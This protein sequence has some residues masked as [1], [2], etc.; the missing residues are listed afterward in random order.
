MNSKAFNAN[1]AIPVEFEM[2]KSE[3]IEWKRILSLLLVLFLG[4]ILSACNF[5]GKTSEPS[6]TPEPSKTQISP[7]QDT[8]IGTIGGLVWGDLCINFEEDESI[9]PGCIPSSGD[10]KFVGN[11]I[12]DAGEMGVASATVSLGDGICPSQGNSII[13]TNE[14]GRYSFS[15][16]NPGVYCVTVLDTGT[17]SGVWTYPKGDNA[18]GVGHMTVTLTPG[19]IIDD[20][21]FAWDPIDVL[22]TPAPTA[23]PTSPPCKDRASYVRDVSVP[24][25]TRFDPEES[26]TKTWRFRNEG[27]C[28]WT[29]NYSVVFVSGYAMNASPVLSL[30]GE[31][32]PGDMVDITH[33]FQAPMQ[34]GEYAG[35]WK[36]RNDEGGLF[37]IGSTGRSPFWVQIKVGP[38]PEPEITDWRGAYYDNVKFEGDPVLI[39][40][41]EEIDFDWKSNSPNEEVPKDQ[42][43]VQW[44]R[45]LE[46]QEEIVRFH[47]VMDD[48][49]TLWVDEQLVIDEW[50]QGAS[51][52]V[53][54]D[55]ELKKGKHDLKVEY[56]EADGTAK[57]SLWWETIDEP[58]YD[59]WKGSYWFNKTLDSEWAL[60]RDDEMIDFEWK[61]ESPALGIPAD[62]FSISWERRVEFETGIYTFY[63]KADDGLRV[64]VDEALVIDEWHISNASELYES[65]LELSGVHEI[66]ILYYEQKQHATV[67]FW[68][69]RN[70]EAP[71]AVDDAYEVNDSTLLQVVAPGVLENDTDANGDLLLALLEVD[72][73]NGTLTLNDDGSFEYLPDPG[74]F[75]KDHFQY[76]ASDGQKNSEVAMVTIDVILVNQPPE[77]TADNFN[78]PEDDILNVPDIGVLVN[79]ND[80][81]G[82]PLTAILE[83]AA[84]HG[85]VE[86]DPAGSFEY[87]PDPDF[88]GTDSFTYKAN[89]GYGDSNV[90][91]VTITI[92][93]VNDVPV[94]IDDQAELVYGMPIEINV[95]ENDLGVGDKPL[96]LTIVRDPEFGI[97][98]VSDGQ[99]IYTPK[100]SYLDMDDFIYRVTDA[101]GEFSTATV[102]VTRP[103]EG[104]IP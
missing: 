9:P 82:D 59:G 37:G 85:V 6:V 28:T 70:N 42:F 101:D 61:F 66:S 54:V 1:E 53:T 77:A 17:T 90:V 93:P 75:G 64:Y 96:E 38:E 47:L 49:A 94:A 52:E 35:F 10:L 45:T 22:P 98:E 104:F 78:I 7:T 48:G 25:G 23:A 71:L 95:V 73:A 89:D 65:E 29:T 102:V 74:F 41:D 63:A 79:D 16:L 14:D 43:A 97:A 36:L 19:R 76:Q 87:T 13:R 2:K 46:F 83:T 51:R 18:E 81:D 100:G 15:G 80:P 91:S 5:S 103:V 20:V 69:I 34:D 26:F 8:E 84:E 31:V 55:L 99:I 88:N 86:L 56:F 57:I 21:D 44:T 12:L 4:I 60:V 11:G 32:R 40:N 33:S 58:T 39:R 62:D 68:W 67:Q 3:T 27:T 24:D 92:T 30:L 72:V 50:K